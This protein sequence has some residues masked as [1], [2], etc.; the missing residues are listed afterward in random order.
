MIVTEKLVKRLLK[1][2]A[3][4]VENPRESIRLEPS[5]VDVLLEGPA[6]SIEEVATDQVAV[7]VVLPEEGPLPDSLPVR[8]RLP[9]E[10]IH[11]NANPEKVGVKALPQEPS[12]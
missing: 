6:S 11:A 2:V 8:I 7:S 1:Q 5:R 3:L 4:K 9:I 12:P 10:G